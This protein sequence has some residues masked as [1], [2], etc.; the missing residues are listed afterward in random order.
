[1]SQEDAIRSFVSL[2]N[3]PESIA[4]AI[5]ERNKWD[6]E[7]S[8]E[9]FYNGPPSQKQSL[10][11]VPNDS[12]AASPS[13]NISSKKSLSSRFKS[14]QELVKA[15]A[16][17]DDDDEQNF[18][19]GGG[20]GSGLEV[21]NPDSDRHNPNRIVRDLLKKAENDQ[22]RAVDSNEEPSVNH[23]SG[24]GYKLGDTNNPSKPMGLPEQTNKRLN[25]VTREITFW[26]DGF[27]VGDGK[28]YRYDDPSNASYLL[29]LNNGRAPMALLDVQYGQD[30]D[31]NVI[32]KLDEEYKPP[33]RK[34]GGFH[35]HGNR[36][37]SVVN[38]E[39]KSTVVVPKEASTKKE[40]SEAPEEDE[41]KGDFKVQIRLA[42]G[43]RIVRY[44][45][46]T[47][48]VSSLY[49]FV[50]SETAVQ[51]PF[52][53]NTS[54]PVKNIDNSSKTIKEAGLINSVIVQRWV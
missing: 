19:A 14:F 53:L 40:S 6:L 35:G 22:P 39:Y 9:D 54:F 34:L 20:R 8:V 15:T 11:E 25:K 24:V 4:R 31:V 26:K 27:Q 37:G 51:R 29:D 49:D 28:L 32:K 16:D 17:H 42:D 5:L 10:S 45:N 50:V 3:V 18:F 13:N 23:F 47:D 52:S 12:K 48:S 43:R 38:P 30:V 44:V 46:S 33:K 2:T 7:A 41:P 36:L 1:M 21:E